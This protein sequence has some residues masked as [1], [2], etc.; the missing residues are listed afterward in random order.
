[1]L[2]KGVCLL[3]ENAK[4][5][6]ANTMKELLASFK[7]DVLNHSAHSPDLASSDYYLLTS[8]K[9]HMGGKRFQ[10]PRR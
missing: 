2:T 7:W 5:H 8:L 1:M 6:M 9:L 3:H 4:S 10:P